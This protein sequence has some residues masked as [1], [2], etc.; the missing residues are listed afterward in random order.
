MRAIENKKRTL[1]SNQKLTVVLLAVAIV[2]L[3]VV[4]FTVNYFIAT[5]AYTD[6]FTFTDKDGTAYSIAPLETG[7][8]GLFYPDGEILES[9]TDDGVLCYVTDL[10]T[11][12]Y[13]SKNGAAEEYTGSPMIYSGVTTKNLTSIKVNNEHGSF[14]FALNNNN[15]WYI[16]EYDGAYF[17]EET[18]VKLRSM[19]LYPYY[20]YKVTDRAL[21]QFG[22][23][24]YGL[25][26]PQATVS[27]FYRD[28]EG[29]LKR[30]EM[31]VGNQ[32]VS[33]GDLYYVRC[34]GTDP[35]GK[36][37]ED[38]V[39]VSHPWVTQS[40]YMNI[41]VRELTLSPVENFVYPVLT[42]PVTST[43][44]VEVYNFIV[45]SFTYDENGE[46]TADHEVGLTFV[47]LS[48]RENTERTTLPYTMILEQFKGYTPSPDAV[49]ETMNPHITMESVSL[50]KLLNPNDPEKYQKDLETYGLD[51]P[52]K[53]MYYEA[54]VKDE[55]GKPF[56][57]KNYVYISDL[58]EN[59]TYYA[60]AKVLGSYDGQNYNV[61]AGYDQ[62]V[63]TAQFF[64]PFMEW[65]SLDWVQSNYFQMFITICEEMEFITNDYHV[66]YDIAPY[67]TDGKEG[68]DD[69]KVYLV[70]DKGRKEV[71][72]DYFKTLYL[73][74]LGGTLFGSVN[75]TDEEIADILAD[76]SR[77]LLTHKVRT[78]EGNEHV[79][80]YYW[81]EESKT[82]LSVDGS[83][84]FYVLT[85][86]VE[87]IM[88]D[89]IDVANGIKIE[90]VTPYT[91]IDK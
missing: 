31:Y 88:Q 30:I 55:S 33:G 3:A 36:T 5:K 40:D 4:L 60:T 28:A 15:K 79:Y 6:T 68:A 2:L 81:L 10:G 67:D 50:I 63:E 21:E 23:E 49:Y 53:S 39:Y 41:N 16:K 12:V 7:G 24:E 89:A 76:P 44:Y 51:K 75:A 14:T 69:V 38:A 46:A 86:A 91:Q 35:A 78:S 58:T 29:T 52:K 9:H 64:F 56:Y 20:Q 48:Q 43:T 8:Y 61:L 25:D 34:V 84:E 85:S 45:S 83:T 42:Y 26:Q 82:L 80:S 11:K 59:N 62:I 13:V 27:I 87:K 72:L 57:L 54:V 17:I 66:F 19:C 73:N 47:P 74:L 18:F 65:N 32:V 77:H 71:N 90:A 1:A 37:L 70:T 22:L